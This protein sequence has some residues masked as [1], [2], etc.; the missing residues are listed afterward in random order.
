M[1]IPKI[2]QDTSGNFKVEVGN[3]N[4]EDGRVKIVPYN[5]NP[6]PIELSKV[7]V[8][9]ALDNAQQRVNF[10][11]NTQF[12]TNGRLEFQGNSSI[13][14]GETQLTAKGQKLDAAAA[15]RIIKIPEVEIVRGTVDG[16]VSVAIQPQK[17][18]K[19]DSNLFC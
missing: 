13:V 6:Q 9:A 15:T 18:L 11:G 1:E 17:S 8:N 12:Q 2:E 16:T 4:V 19:I 5:K 14:T 10:N 3:I 7:N